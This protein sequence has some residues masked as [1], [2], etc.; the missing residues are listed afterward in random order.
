MLGIHKLFSIPRCSNRKKKH[1][2][3]VLKKLQK[4]TKGILPEFCSFG[5]SNTTL[6]IP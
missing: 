3:S 6:I 2:I 5:V 1:E 4:V